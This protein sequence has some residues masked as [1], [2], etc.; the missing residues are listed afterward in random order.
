MII[1][2]IFVVRVGP[3]LPRYTLP[4]VGMLFMAAGLVGMGLLG[5]VGPSA[6]R[7]IIDIGGGF[8]LSPAW[9]IGVIS[10]LLGVGLAMVLIPAQTVVQEQSSDDIRGRVLTVQLTLANGLGIPPLILAGLLADVFGIPAIVI[11]L[12]VILLG[13]AALNRWYV[14]RLPEPPP[15]HFHTQPIPMPGE[16]PA[17]VE[18]VNA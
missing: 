9:L 14:R 16:T 4:M 3:R 15:T 13:L 1:A 5:L 12:G 17:M 8:T 11:A 7:I 6:S 10:P 18:E 2:S